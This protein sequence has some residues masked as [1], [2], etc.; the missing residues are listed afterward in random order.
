MS[1][2][3]I[4]RRV[5]VDRLAYVD[6][7]LAGLRALPLADP[8]AFHADRRNAA[9]AESGLRRALEALFDLARHVLAKV[10]GVGVTEY[11][12]VARA[13]GERGVFTQT[14]TALFER[15]AGYRNRMVHVYDE[16]TPAELYTICTE[17]LG[18]VER[19]AGAL[20]AWIAGHAD[21]MSDEL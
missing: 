17:H 5:V 7:M 1:P 3:P 8:R 21:E 19:L 11:K 2:G 9:A 10:H 13:L 6:A 12:A 15:L 18:D 14:E 4:S 16:V 20:R